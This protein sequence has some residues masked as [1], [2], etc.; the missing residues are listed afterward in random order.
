MSLDED[1]LHAKVDEY[2]QRAAIAQAKAAQACGRL[3]SL[4]ENQGDQAKFV[5]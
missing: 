2:Q 1:S 3:L 5:M 4:A